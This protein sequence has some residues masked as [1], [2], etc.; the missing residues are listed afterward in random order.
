M[1]V[2]CPLS[3]VSFQA[4]F[5]EQAFGK[6]P[7]PIFATGARKTIGTLL[8]MAASEKLSSEETHLFG[9]FLLSKLPIERWDASLLELAPLSY[10]STFWSKHLERLSSTVLRLE[11][12]EISKLPT[13][14]IFSKL[15]AE[16]KPL[17]NMKDWLV[18]LNLR[19]EEYYS[20][21]SAEAKKRNKVFR[22]E[23]GETQYSTEEACNSLIEKAL[24]GSLLSPR[25][26]D[27]FPEIIASWAARVGEFP[28]TY[29]T[30]VS[31]EKITLSNFWKNIIRSAFDTRP[32]SYGVANILTDGVTVEDLDELL[33]HCQVNIPV[34]TLQSRA[35]FLELE[36]VKEV[37]NEFRPSNSGKA[38][39]LNTSVEILSSKEVADILGEVSTVAPITL[40]KETDPLAPK[41][42]DYPTLSAFV[43]A[44][45]RYAEL[46]K[47]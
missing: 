5:F 28:Q 30:Q 7:H 38:S 16:G 36:K 3:G 8:P 46:K 21:I 6:T 29:F 32:G 25:E 43:K 15:S 41:K 37:I 44:R 13:L 18:E 39:S 45:A 4:T 9:C 2:K 12:K 17:G 42:E 1:K 40:M 20:P 23:I 27:K 24:R 47:V 26:K 19:I 33:E 14:V 10:W 34:G 11:A 31:G 22:S 35:L